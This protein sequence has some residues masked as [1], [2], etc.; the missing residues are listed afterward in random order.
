MTKKYGALDE[1]L[2]LPLPLPMS[3]VRSQKRREQAE[4][5]RQA[6]E[7]RDQLEK[8]EEQQDALQETI[9]GEGAAEAGEEQLPKARVGRMRVPRMHYR[10]V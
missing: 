8:T 1:V 4:K 5:R 2:N 10:R 6:I 3:A 9:A 7:A